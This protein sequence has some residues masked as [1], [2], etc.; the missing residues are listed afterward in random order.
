MIVNM[1]THTVQYFVNNISVGS[2]NFLTS[3]TGFQVIDFAFDDYDSGF[4]VDNIKILNADNLS[5]SEIVHNNKVHIYP[6]PTTDLLHIP[7]IENIKSVEV[8]D[9]TGKLVLKDTSGKNRISVSFLNKGLYVIKITTN[10][11]AFTTKFSKK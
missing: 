9:T 2:K 4:T 1:A 3:A 10:H 7:T 6:N 11:S 8:Y 5:T